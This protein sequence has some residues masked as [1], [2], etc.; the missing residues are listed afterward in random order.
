MWRRDLQVD[1]LRLGNCWF[2]GGREE[3]RAKDRFKGLPG[4]GT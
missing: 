4:S 1:K 3:G 2:V